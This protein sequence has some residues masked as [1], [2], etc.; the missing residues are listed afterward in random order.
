MPL[1]HGRRRKGKKDEKWRESA[2]RVGP[3]IKTRFSPPFF[4]IATHFGGIPAYFQRTASPLL[5]RPSTGLEIR[6]A[7]Q[8]R[9]MH[10]S[11]TK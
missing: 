5:P 4:F 10:G 7:A 8:I 11:G 3:E 1:R 6:I 2:G 9:R